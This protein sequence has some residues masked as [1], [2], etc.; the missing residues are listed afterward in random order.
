MA[1]YCFRTVQ[2]TNTYS[3]LVQI[4]WIWILNSFYKGNKGLPSRLK[5]NLIRLD[6]IS[7][8]VPWTWTGDTFLVQM[9]SRNWEFPLRYFEEISDTHLVFPF[10]VPSQKWS[11][12]T[13]DHIEY[14]HMTRAGFKMK[15]GLFEE[16]MRFIDSLPLISNQYPLRHP[17]TK[18][19]L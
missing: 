15:R 12:V 18:T 6:L 13:S 11:P 1:T 8:K 19:E 10:R 14:L 5:S 16:R 7:T 9:T 17:E 2:Y 4:G 3:K